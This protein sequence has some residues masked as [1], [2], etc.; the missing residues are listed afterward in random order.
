[1]KQKTHPNKAFLIIKQ[2]CI[3]HPIRNAFFVNT[4]E[5]SSTWFPQIVGTSFP[6]NKNFQKLM[7]VFHLRGRLFFAP[8]ARNHSVFNFAPQK[9]SLL[10]TRLAVRNIF[11]TNSWV[12]LQIAA[13]LGE[14]YSRLGDICL[15]L[16]HYARNRERGARAIKIP[17]HIRN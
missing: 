2:R 16:H 4:C 15:V 3:T 11:I 5:M 12:S 10:A 9:S 1:V 17:G 14:I 6:V 8:S 13:R 7:P